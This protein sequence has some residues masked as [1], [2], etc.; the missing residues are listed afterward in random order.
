MIQSPIPLISLASSDP[1]SNSAF[2]SPAR[3]GFNASGSCLPRVRS[4]FGTVWPMGHHSET[5]GEQDGS[6]NMDFQRMWRPRFGVFSVS[7]V[8]QPDGLPKVAF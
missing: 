8:E 1:T 5:L 6:K 4:P 2:R 7:F 3:P